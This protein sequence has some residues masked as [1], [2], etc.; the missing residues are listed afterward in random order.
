ME[1][2]LTFTT[3]LRGNTMQAQ[4]H[5]RRYP[6]EQ[7]FSLGKLA[8]KTFYIERDE[9]NGMPHTMADTIRKRAK[10]R[11]KRVRVEVKEDGRL[12]LTIQKQKR[13]E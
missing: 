10:A 1:G 6:W 4:M 8:K 11:G 12:K 7:W 5:G 13:K 3:T 9:Y 2:P